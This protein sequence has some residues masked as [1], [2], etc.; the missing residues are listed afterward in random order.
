MTDDAPP[1]AAGSALP[2][3][4]ISPITVP[5]APPNLPAPP[6][7]APQE[8]RDAYRECLF[9]LGPDVRWLHAALTLQHQVVTA[10]M[11]SR[12]R[13][14]RYAAALLLW[15]RVYTAGQ[16]LL[17]AAT[18]GQYGVCPPL[19]RAALEWLAAEEAVVGE[20]FSE[21]EAWLDAAL[22][23]HPALGAT[24]LGMG[25]YLAN[26]GLAGQP[27]LGPIYRAVSEFSRPHFGVSLLLG[28]PE[29]N[30]QKLAVRWADRSFHHGWAQLVLGWQIAL[31]ERQTG[32]A[33]GSGLFAAEAAQREAYQQLRRQADTLLAQRDRCR[34]SW[35]DA[36]GRERLLIENFRRQPSGAPRRWLL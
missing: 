15:S 30:P 17:Q 12:Y 36:D 3:K 9:T 29:S 21:F 24:N 27:M 16:D 14:R 8:V 4:R 35:M 7:T 20:E 33:I 28:A 26:Q 18:W 2:D 19:T 22:G 13:N 25:H 10:S 23:P 1:S 34:A 6:D 32:F 5:A 31:Q 11:P